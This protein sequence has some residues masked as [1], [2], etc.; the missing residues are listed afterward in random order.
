MLF[1]RYLII[2]KMIGLRLVIIIMKEQK[3][4]L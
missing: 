4:L 1:V 3:V 2:A